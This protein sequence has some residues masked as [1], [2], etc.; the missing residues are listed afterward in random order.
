M[1]DADSKSDLYRYWSRDIQ[2]G[3]GYGDC[4]FVNHDCIC[5]DGF[6]HDLS[7][8]RQRGCHVP[9]LY[10]PVVYG[11]QLALSL[12]ILPFII[13]KLHQ[14]T[15]IARL[16]MKC[17]AAACLLHMLYCILIIS[18]GFINYPVVVF[19]LYMLTSSI[20]AGKCIEIYSFVHP[21]TAV[22][23]KP[24]TSAKHTLY[25]FYIFYRIAELVPLVIATVKYSDINN[26]ENDLP[27]NICMMTLS[28][29]I[30]IEAISLGL[31][32]IIY[33]S[34][35]VKFIE[36]LSVGQRE[37]NEKHSRVP[38]SYLQKVKTMIKRAGIMV[39]SIAIPLFFPPIVIISTNFLPG[40]YVFFSFSVSCAIP[41]VLFSAE[42]V[43]KAT[44]KSSE[45]QASKSGEPSNK[46]SDQV[47]PFNSA[48][49]N[50]TN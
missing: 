3:N 8:I 16:S 46:T 41:L 6:T 22:A 50:T 18:L 24:A 14:S 17:S 32:I 20:S 7:Y 19:T 49:N 21:L 45:V 23:M 26:R 36:E 15:S 35:M 13:V 11:I 12:M 30:G 38:S 28:L 29:I 43:T 25:G 4:D 27:W 44:K 42:Y 39:P 34:K 5:H 33:A 10:F 1:C 31:F 47:A 2:C 9:K 37:K 40:S 48:S